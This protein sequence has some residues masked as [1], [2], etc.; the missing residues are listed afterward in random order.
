MPRP[1]EVTEPANIPNANCHRF[2]SDV[3]VECPHTSNLFTIPPIPPPNVP[4]TQSPRPAS[5]RA[6]GVAVWTTTAAPAAAPA[7]AVNGAR[8][9]SSAA[10][11]GIIRDK[12]GGCF[13]ARGPF[14]QHHRWEKA[15]KS[16]KTC[17]RSRRR[18]RRRERASRRHP[19]RA[20]IVKILLQ[21]FL[22]LV[23]GHICAD[24]LSNSLRSYKMGI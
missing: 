1:T 7:A 8:T 15:E 23:L 21:L 3:G 18:R 13:G 4:F 2:K 6:S 16:G 5:S 22:T 19:V 11:A 9:T 20:C 12:Y 17:S 14:G 24:I 10:S